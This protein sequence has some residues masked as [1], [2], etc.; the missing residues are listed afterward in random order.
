VSATVTHLRGILDTN[1]V[2]MLA[3]IADPAGP[4][5]RATDYRRHA[6]A[7]RSVGPLMASDDAERAAG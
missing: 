2:I 7:D 1:S 5:G 6:L 3:R 4:A